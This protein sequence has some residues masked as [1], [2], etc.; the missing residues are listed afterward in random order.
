MQLLDGKSLSTK[1]KTHIKTEVD[2][3]TS[4]GKRAPHLVAILIGANPAS[5]TYVAAKIKS[6]EEVG[7]QST[8]YRYDASITEAEL[9]QKINE[10]NADSSID[11]LLV[12]LP[13]PKHINETKVVETVDYRKDVDGFHPTNIG[14]MAKGLPCTLPAT[15]YGILKLLEEYKIE[16]AGKH[17]VVI[18]RS[19]IVGSPMSI[20]MARNDYPGNATVTIC[21]SKTKDLSSFTRNAD[22]IIAA[23]GIPQ[24]LK[25]DMV[26]DGVVIVD[27][28]TNRIEDATKKSGFRLVGDVDFDSV[29]DKCSYISPV[30]GG[31]GPMTIA[32]LLLNTLDTYKRGE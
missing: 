25:A 29:K 5:E 7:F 23:V 31:V 20:L 2:S 8:L 21:H 10:I 17:C 12:Q 30:P 22:I 11:G 1:L 27:V 32:A 4:T 28:G 14:R 24:M 16:T 6:C 3:L 15:P 26:K 9:L 13:L 19:H 18:G